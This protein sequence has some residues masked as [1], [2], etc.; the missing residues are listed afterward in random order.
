[1]TTGPSTTVPGATR[2]RTAGRPARERMLRRRRRA[3]VLA[4]LAVAAV[5]V[6][7]DLGNGPAPRESTGEAG[8]AAAAGGGG[9]VADEFTAPSATPSAPA[10]VRVPARGLGTFTVAPGGT[11][12]AGRGQLLRYQVQ[13]EDGVGQVPAEFAATVDQTLADPRSWTAGGEWAFQR[14]SGGQGWKPDFVI[15]LASPDTVDR[16]CSP[17]DT[18]GYT[19]CRVGNRVVVNLARWLL[20]VPEFHGDVATYRRYVVNHEV[21]HRLGRGHLACPQPGALAPVMLQQ[22]LGLQGCRPNAWPYVDGKLVTGPPTAG[23]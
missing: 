8:S 3:G 18:K 17:L 1:M 13:V 5:L 2:A 7:V 11:G 21:G 4:L 12:V 22:T 6:G 20:A 9:P 23:Q 19:S 16:L 15:T 14:V 10:G